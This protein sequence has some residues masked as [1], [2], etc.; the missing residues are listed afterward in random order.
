MTLEVKVLRCAARAEAAATAD[1]DEEKKKNRLNFL[2][3][4][5]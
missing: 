1:A 5:V 3:V 4:G 2:N